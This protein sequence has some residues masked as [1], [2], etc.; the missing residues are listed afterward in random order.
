V[1]RATVFMAEWLVSRMDWLSMTAPSHLRGELPLQRSESK[2]V[3]LKD[4]ALVNGRSG[5]NKLVNIN[6]R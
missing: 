2:A 3:K 4:K 1:A 6:K 5:E